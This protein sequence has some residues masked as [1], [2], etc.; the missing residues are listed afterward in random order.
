MNKK[1]L[2][3]VMA[4]AMLA[5][6]VAPVLAA[7]ENTMSA[8]ELGLLIKEVRET[9]VSKTFTDTREVAGNRNGNESGKSVYYI[10]VNG[11]KVDDA[12][13]DLTAANANT[14]LQGALQT[15]LG[16]LAKGLKQKYGQK[17]LKKNEIKYMQTEFR[18]HIQKISQKQLH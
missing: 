15:A 2:S 13:I 16:G 11:V 8:A 3:V 7:E 4:G 9:L 10:K 5:T 18:K 14:T 6:S 17:D 1:K 12:D